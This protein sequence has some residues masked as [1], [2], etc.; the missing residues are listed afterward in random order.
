MFFFQI[1]LEILIWQVFSQ[2]KYPKNLK[3][4][5]CNSERVRENGV[6]SER[7]REE[8]NRITWIII[9]TI[10]FSRK[11]PLVIVV[12]MFLLWALISWTLFFPNLGDIKNLA[13]VNNF[14]SFMKLGSK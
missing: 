11:D 5:G 3:I 13:A 12:H 4:P 2:H 14:D 8:R 9:T 1:F 7:V 10:Y 6:N